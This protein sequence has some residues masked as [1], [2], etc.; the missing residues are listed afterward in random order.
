MLVSYRSLALQAF[1]LASAAQLVRWALCALRVCTDRASISLISSR[2]SIFVR[3]VLGVTEQAD[4]ACTPLRTLGRINTF[5]KRSRIDTFERGKTHGWLQPTRGGKNIR[6]AGPRRSTIRLGHRRDFLCVDAA[7]VCGVQ[8][9]E[10]ERR[11]R[12][13]VLPAGSDNERR[14]RGCFDRCYDSFSHRRRDRPPPEVAVV[15]PRVVLLVLRRARVPPRLLAA[16]G[17]WWSLSTRPLSKIPKTPLM[18]APTPQ[19]LSARAKDIHPG[20]VYVFL[21]CV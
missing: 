16:S 6:R 8:R 4:S 17:A 15:Q 9:R 21:A 12:G 19:P 11:R 5:E 10:L 13:L 1:F 20:V 3:P 14:R 7:S 2:L 18:G